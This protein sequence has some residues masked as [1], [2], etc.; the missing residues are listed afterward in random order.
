MVSSEKVSLSRVQLAGALDNLPVGIT[1]IDPN[2]RILYYNATC[3]RYVDRKP[4]YIGRDIRACHAKPA[5]VARI[6]AMLADL[7]A[8]RT[9]EI[10]YETRRGDHRL[11]VT[12]VPFEIGGE[13]LGYIQ[14]FVVLKA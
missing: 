1:I 9:A 3:A 6:D 12:V 4:E 5:S 14:S 7:R 2:G 10:H 13:R 8:G 11:A